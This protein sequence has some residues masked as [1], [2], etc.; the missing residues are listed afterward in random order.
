[1]RNVHA[2]ISVV[3]QSPSMWIHLYCSYMFWKFS[4][5]QVEE[6]W[7]FAGVSLWRMSSTSAYNRTSSYNRTYEKRIIEEGPKI[8]RIG[9]PLHVTGMGSPLHVSTSTYQVYFDNLKHWIFETFWVGVREFFVLNEDFKL[10]KHVKK[11]PCEF[12]IL[13]AVTEHAFCFS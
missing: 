5:Q 9:S 7:M 4:V 13:T 8:T 2:V 3:V 6:W 1:M 10:K 12:K 11:E